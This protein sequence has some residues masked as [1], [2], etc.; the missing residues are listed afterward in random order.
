M[1][2][3]RG[4]GG[5]CTRP[6][7]PRDDG[8]S[9]NIRIPAGLPLV[10]LD[11]VL[12]EQVLFNLI[13]NA[14][15]YSPAGSSIDISAHEQ[16]GSVVIEVAD[17]GVGLAEG[18]REQIFEK[19]Y[20]GTASKEGTRGAG[21]GLAIA[22]AI[23]SAH[24]GSIWAAARPGGG[25]LFSFSLPVGSTP[26]SPTKRKRKKTD[27]P[28]GP[29]STHS[30]KPRLLVI[31][32]DTPMRRFLRAALDNE[33]YQVVEADTGQ[34]GLTS[35]LARMPDLILLD[36]GLP[37]MD[38]TSILKR[39]REWSQVPIVVLSAR[40]QEADK[41]DALNRRRRLPDQALRGPRAACP[42][43]RRAEACGPFKERAGNRPRSS[44]PGTS[45]ST[46]AAGG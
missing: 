8:R 39:V 38:G 32:D 25:A 16:E 45:S 44:A 18:E 17:R 20:R 26:I 40:G 28:G 41:V 24:G 7:A 29:Q 37:D 6:V 14:L 13:D 3:D 15:K 2:P 36:L 1:V 4:R 31:E 5:V 35:H 21:L 11:G 10:P 34:A 33:G 19:L 22:R 30:A 23:V 9:V 43:S 12:V 27:E 42:H 46:W